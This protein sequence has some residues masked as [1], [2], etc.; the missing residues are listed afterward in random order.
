MTAMKHLLGR[1]GAAL[2]IALVA[3]PLAGCRDLPAEV[4]ADAGAP[5]VAD[6]APPD[7]NSGPHPGELWVMA[8]NLQTFPKAVATVARVA[9][10]VDGLGADVIGVEEIDDLAAFA[11]LDTL[12]PDYLGLTATNGDGYSRVGLLYRGDTVSIDGV[13]TLFLGDGEAFPR[14]PL[15]AHV[16]GQGVDV[17]VI[18]VHLKALGDATSEARRKDAVIKLDA[19]I[20]AQQ[21]AAPER[22]YLIMGDWNDQVTDVAPDN[23]FQPMLDHPE[24]YDVLTLPLAQ[25]GDSSYIPIPGVIDH[26]VLTENALG[27][28]GAGDTQV[29]HLDATDAQYESIISDHR[30]VLTRF[31][32]AP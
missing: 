16:V 32:P 26:M 9:Q 5:G 20:Q 1:A 15:A 29:L 18:V 13:E 4:D 19:W 2:V 10:V 8:W 23:V 12:L 28:W 6:A 14:P 22:R 27:E 24:R 25:A 3:A 31:R 30:P 17:T 21:A 11:S 7:A